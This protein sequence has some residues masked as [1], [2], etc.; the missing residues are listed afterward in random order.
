MVDQV[1]ER[2]TNWRLRGLRKIVR[3]IEGDGSDIE[4]F[5]RAEVPETRQFIA[6][7]YHATRI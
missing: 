5:I 1:A 3:K 2:P 4:N 6:F 7:S